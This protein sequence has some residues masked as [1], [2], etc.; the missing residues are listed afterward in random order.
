MTEMDIYQSPITPFVIPQFADSAKQVRSQERILDFLEIGFEGS[1]SKV[2]IRQKE[3]SCLTASPPDHFYTLEV[4]VTDL[5]KSKWLSLEV[6]LDPARFVSASR[7]TT[8]I[9]LACPYQDQFSASLRFLG[10]DGGFEDLGLGNFKPSINEEYRPVNLSRPLADLYK[11]FGRAPDAAK[12]ILFAPAYTG[13]RF[14]LSM[15]NIFVTSE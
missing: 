4:D 13:L 6:L 5:V 12:L 8:L 14:S 2:F 7:I 3:K 9:S 11:R 10:K 15:L 1:E